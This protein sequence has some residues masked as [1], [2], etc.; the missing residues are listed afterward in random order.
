MEIGGRMPIYE[1][2]CTECNDIF[3]ILCSTGDDAA[4]PK[5]PK[6]G[7]EEL[8]RVL[9]AASFTMGSDGAASS[10]VE[11]RTCGSG[12]CTTYEVPGPTS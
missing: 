2:K 9:S 11:T 3:E 10:K 6:C 5:C 1:F 8:E 12:N 7:K 4:S